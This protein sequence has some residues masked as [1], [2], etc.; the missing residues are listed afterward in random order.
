MHL[1]AQYDYRGH[2]GGQLYLNY[3]MPSRSGSPAR[4][5]PGR[6]VNG[7]RAHPVGQPGYGVQAHI[8]MHVSAYVA[9]R[10]PV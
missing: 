7:L 6:G 2:R 1:G 3:S 8:Y 5:F 4:E 9:S 10:K